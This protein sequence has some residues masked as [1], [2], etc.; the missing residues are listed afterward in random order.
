MA[1]ALIREEG[2]GQP[3]LVLFQSLLPGAPGPQ[4]HK[5]LPSVEHHLF[6]KGEMRKSNNRNALKERRPVEG[7]NKALPWK[8]RR[9]QS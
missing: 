8:H 5:M 7:E 3:S 4:Q 1:G 2:E 9:Q 6:K